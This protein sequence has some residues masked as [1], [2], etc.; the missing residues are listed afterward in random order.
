MVKAVGEA[1]VYTITN[2]K[3][4]P[5]EWELNIIVNCNEEKGDVLE[6]VNYRGLKLTDQYLTITE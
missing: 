3:S 1:G 5:A 6:R 4:T 2:R